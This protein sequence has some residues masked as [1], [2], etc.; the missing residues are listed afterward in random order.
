VLNNDQTKF[1]VSSKSDIFY[2][3]LDGRKGSPYEIDLD[4][5]EGIDKIERIFSDDNYFYILA[6]K[7]D[8]KLGFFLAMVNIKEPEDDV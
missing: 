5:Q 2:V 3:D 1:I 4:D 8:E 6:N 7:K